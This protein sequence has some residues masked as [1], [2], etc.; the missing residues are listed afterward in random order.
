MPKRL[1]KNIFSLFL[2][3]LGRQEAPRGFQDGA[4]RP[5]EAA[6]NSPSGPKVA[7]IAPRW[8]PKWTQNRRNI[9]GKID[10]KS[11]ASWNRFFEGF[12][13][14]FGGKTEACWL[15]NRAKIDPNFEERFFAKN[16]FSC[17]KTM[18]L[19]VEGIEVGS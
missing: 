16:C 1:P 18:F 3:G 4:R 13:L 5:Q 19:K 2:V 12:W 11:D 7:N 8:L 14:I 15:Q 9:D 10:R 6:K 17:G